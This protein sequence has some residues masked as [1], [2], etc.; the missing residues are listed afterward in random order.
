[1]V[2]LI[3]FIIVGA[4]SVAGCLIMDMAAG[5]TWK[6]VVLTC[7]VI[8]NLYDLAALILFPKIEYLQW[9]YLVEEDRVVIRHGIFW[10]DKDIIPIVRI[11]NIT[12]SQGPVMKKYGLFKI[13]MV[14]ASGT[15]TIEGLKQDVADEI[16]ENLKN[17]LYSRLAAREG[18][19]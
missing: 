1:M 4:V 11:Q 3:T 17:R 10:V 15:F 13:E 16:G 14:L 2:R 6:Y 5:A 19:K 12:V 8:I 18:E 9:G 7:V